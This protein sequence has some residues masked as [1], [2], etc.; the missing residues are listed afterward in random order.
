V[1]ADLAG[2]ASSSGF[3]LPRFELAGRSAFAEG[4]FVAF[5]LVEGAGGLA[6]AASG[7]FGIGLFAGEAAARFA[8]E[9]RAAFFCEASAGFAIGFL[10]AEAAARFAWRI[11][12]FGARGEGGAVGGGRTGGGRTWGAG[13]VEFAEGRSAGT[14][15]SFAAT[16]VAGFAIAGEGRLAA[17]AGGACS[18]LAWD[19]RLFAGES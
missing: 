12:A 5:E 8:G 1:S 19:V 14:S 7:G 11:V 4:F 6:G 17:E 9:A 10:C 2:F 18:A 13:R 16:V 15:A 3:T